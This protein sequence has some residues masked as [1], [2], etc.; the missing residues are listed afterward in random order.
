M[1]GL[2]RV[3]VHLGACGREPYRAERGCVVV[4]GFLCSGLQPST[5]NTIFPE[6]GRDNDFL[7]IFIIGRR[8]FDTLGIGRHGTLL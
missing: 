8:S 2:V 4:E 6:I 7:G 5:K 1:A 3:P